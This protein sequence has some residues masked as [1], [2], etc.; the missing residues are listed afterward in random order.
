MTWT[1]AECGAVYSERAAA[2]AMRDGCE[3]GCS[4]L[5]ISEDIPPAPPAPAGDAD[6]RSPFTS[7]VLEVQRAALELRRLCAG[8]GPETTPRPHTVAWLWWDLLAL[9]RA[10]GVTEW[11][12]TVAELVGRTGLSDR[13]VR[14]AL[15]A[16]ARFGWLV[17]RNRG[18]AGIQIEVRS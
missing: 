7:T 18:R 12:G 5:D 17:S 8:E 16:L 2:V 4:G 14:S 9:T 15:R 13:T 1:C 3:A 11:D 6:A 10:V